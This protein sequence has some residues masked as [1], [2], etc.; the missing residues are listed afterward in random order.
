MSGPL[1]AVL[2][3]IPPGSMSTK[4]DLLK[5]LEENGEIVDALV[6]CSQPP[7]ADRQRLWLRPQLSRV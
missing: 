6:Q 1:T 4:V 7:L 2:A 5:H 3:T